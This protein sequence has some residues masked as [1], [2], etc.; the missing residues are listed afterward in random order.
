MAEAAARPSQGR[1]SRGGAF[2][3]HQAGDNEQ[4]RSTR[5]G[6]MKEKRGEKSNRGRK[7]NRAVLSGIKPGQE[8]W[9]EIRCRII[10]G[11]NEWAMVAVRQLIATGQWQKIGP[12]MS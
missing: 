1:R 8:T 11:S 2:L 3:E 4:H 12:V 6:A 5:S 9:D 10:F 7:P